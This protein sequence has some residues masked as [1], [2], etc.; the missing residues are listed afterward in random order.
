MAGPQLLMLL[1]K[2]GHECCV[3]GYVIEE[4]AE[5]SS[6]KRRTA[7]SPSRDWCRA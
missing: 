5:T 7:L 3:D 4:A 1:E 6:P 2:S